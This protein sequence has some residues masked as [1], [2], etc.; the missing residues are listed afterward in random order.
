MELH[1]DDA[2]NPLPASL[3]Q[4]PAFNNDI[5]IQFYEKGIPQPAADDMDRLYQNLYS[6][7]AQFAM[8]RDLGAVHTYV[9]RRGG[10]PLAVLVFEKQGRSIRV[11]NSVIKLDQQET[12]RF[13]REVFSRFPD[14]GAVSF[15]AV[16]AEFTSLPLPMQRY[17]RSEDIVVSLPPTI[18]EYLDSLGKSTKKNVKYYMNKL[19]RNYPSFEYRVYQGKDITEQLVRDI[20]EVKRARMADKNQVMTGDD[21]EIERIMKIARVHGLVGVATIDDKVAAGSIGY[22]IGGHAFGGVLAHDPQYDSY[23]IGMLCC[24]QTISACIE[25][26]CK[27][28]HFQWGKD[29]YKFRLLGVQR[30]LFDVV[31]YRSTAHMLLHP[32]LALRT[33]VGGRFREF[34]D[35]LT[36]PQNSEKLAARAA[37]GTMRFVKQLRGQTAPKKNE[38]SPAE[39]ADA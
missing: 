8:T 5:S 34:K 37:N 28:Y 32:S 19:K 9:A 13:V 23:W 24:Y 26:G 22:L 1:Y 7:Y 10:D 4:E 17:R 30:D 29:E 27:E 31:V 2:F 15:H 11:V 36:D 35:W 33:E 16:Q 12:A 14:V 3:S 20:V 39:T 18:N 6:S 25:R 21:G 38:S